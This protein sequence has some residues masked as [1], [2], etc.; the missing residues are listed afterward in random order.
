MTTRHI[1]SEDHTLGN[2]IVQQLRTQDHVVFAAYKQPNPLEKK[3]VLRVDST[4]QSTPQ[5]EIQT[6]CVA[7]AKLFQTLEDQLI[8]QSRSTR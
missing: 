4:E 8:S 6:A 3:I 2:I 7:L 1:D 5:M